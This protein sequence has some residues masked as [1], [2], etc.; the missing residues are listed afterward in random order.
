VTITEDGQIYNPVFRFV[1]RFVL[2]Y[3]S[4]MRGVLRDLGNHLG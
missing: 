1:S 2:G 4:T 3:E